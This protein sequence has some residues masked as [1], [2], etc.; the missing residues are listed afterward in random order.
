MISTVKSFIAPT[1]CS[2]FNAIQNTY[3]KLWIIRYV[4]R[5][6]PEIIGRLPFAERSRA[7]L[8]KALYSWIHS[9]Y[10]NQF[11]S[12]S[13]CLRIPA[14]WTVSPFSFRN[15]RWATFGIY[16]V[17]Q[18]VT[19]TRSFLVDDFFFSLLLKRK[20]AQLF[21]ITAGLYNLDYK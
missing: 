21:Q 14:L 5:V 20:R 4:D 1:V 7:S 11:D 10:G 19:I 6:H 16:L 3:S 18:N 8:L 9:F 15:Y 2:R 12:G 17:I 13:Q